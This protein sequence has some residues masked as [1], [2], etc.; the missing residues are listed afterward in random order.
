MSFDIFIACFHGGDEGAFPRH[1]MEEAFGPYIDSREPRCL[2]LR[3]ADGGHSDVYVE[4]K[5]HISFFGVNRPAASP[6]FWQAVFEILRQT[7]TLLLWPGG[8]H[9]V[10]GSP[11]TLQHLPADVAET[12]GVP[13]IA[14]SPDQIRACVTG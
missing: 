5:E 12:F 3:F 10:V 4:D 11:A 13:I 1:V 9:P 7:P 14:V 6:E 2:V 8:E